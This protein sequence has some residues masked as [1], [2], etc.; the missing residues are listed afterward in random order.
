[1]QQQDDVNANLQ[2]CLELPNKSNDANLSLYG[3]WI[4]QLQVQQAGSDCLLREKEE[5]ERRQNALAAEATADAVR[6]NQM[7]QEKQKKQKASEN[8]NALAAQT[9][10]SI[11]KIQQ[12]QLVIRDLQNQ[13]NATDRKL[14]ETQKNLNK[15]EEAR[16][17]Q[18]EVEIRSCA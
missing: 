5:E 7:Q 8:L 16:R 6:K 17:T 15:S 4:Q 13:K 12:M 3:A 2:R 11:A 9:A 10:A 18:D 1:M 14:E